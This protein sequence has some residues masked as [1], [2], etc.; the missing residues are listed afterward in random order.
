MILA[1]RVNVLCVRLVVL[2]GREGTDR[3][4]TAF[5]EIEQGPASRAEEKLAKLVPPR[6]AAV[7]CL[8]K[9]DPAGCHSGGKAWP[10][11]LDEEG[12]V[13]YAISHLL[14][15]LAIDDALRDH[16]RGHLHPDVRS[17]GPIPLAILEQRIGR[18]SPG[19]IR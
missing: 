11:I 17:N 2:L 3:V 5:C 16:L 7:V 6:L 8:D 1:I 9:C 4:L 12:G 15:K 14:A 19:S 13:G 10:A 18:K